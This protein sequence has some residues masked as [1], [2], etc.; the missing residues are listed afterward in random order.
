MA[1]P[2]PFP[3]EAISLPYGATSAPYAPKNPHKGT[4]FSSRRLG[5]VSGT[6]IYASGLGTVTRNEKGVGSQTPTQSRANSGAGN[7]FDIR[8]D[9]GG[10]TVR[11]MHR[12]AVEG[13]NVGS[14]VEL[15]DWIGR[16]GTTGASTGA[17]L[18]LEV[19]VGGV[20]V[21]PARYFD[22]NHYVGDGSGAG[23]GA[24]D[25]PLD[26]NDLNQIVARVFNTPVTKSPVDGA[27]DITLGQFMAQAGF[28]WQHRLVR[29]D[30]NT[31]T[32]AGDLLRYEPA[33]HTN[34]RNTIQAIKDSLATAGV[35]PK[36]IQDAA[37]AGAR[38]GVSGLTLKAV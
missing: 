15:G 16:V 21:D 25:M 18:H 7:Y 12:L 11:H 8:Y 34:T 9:F 38:A 1:L 22:F 2:L 13:P 33:E 14:R 37:E 29:P 35:D 23:T 31:P 30:T 10:I 32:A 17:H 20:R 19:W 36:I 3:K 26:T 6:G 27:T 4:D 24:G 5:V 28:V